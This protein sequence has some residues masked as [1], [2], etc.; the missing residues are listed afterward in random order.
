MF[1]HFIGCHVVLLAVSFALIKIF[2]SMRSHLLFI[3]EPALLVF[4]S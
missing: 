1:P 3:V 4:C 2:S